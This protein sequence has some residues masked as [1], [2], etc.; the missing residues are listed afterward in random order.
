M[1]GAPTVIEPG[2]QTC[3][4]PISMRRLLVP[5]LLLLAAIL[6]GCSKDPA[7]PR[8]EV[9]PAVAW[10][11]YDLP[12]ATFEPCVDLQAGDA[13]LF[14]LA[15][16]RFALIAPEGSDTRWHPVAEFPTGHALT[17]V[18]RDYFVYPLGGGGSI[19]QSISINRR[20]TGSEVP[21]ETQLHV[22]LLGPELSGDARYAA[23]DNHTPVVVIDDEGRMLAPVFDSGVNAPG[24]LYVYLIQLRHDASVVAANVER[25]IEWPHA[26][27]WVMTAGGRFFASTVVATYEVRWDGSITRRFDEGAYDIAEFDGRLV[28]ARFSGIHASSDGGVTWTPVGHAEKGRFFQVGGRLCLLQAGGIS[29]IDLDRGEITRLAT[30]GLPNGGWAAAAQFKDRVYVATREGL[31]HKPAREFFTPRKF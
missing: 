23:W 22:T 3:E 15:P 19:H 4:N 16:R 26:P 18:N 13:D 28:C 7:R 5:G 31:F 9:E 27:F 29:L 25:R 21:S 30:E 12:D 8:T 20:V 24:R 11:R 10:Q 14:V 6:C 2:R 17:F 1:K